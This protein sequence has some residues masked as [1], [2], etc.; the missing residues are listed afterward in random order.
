M[1]RL[2][3]TV[4]ALPVLSLCFLS[5]T[6]AFGAVQTELVAGGFRFPVYATAPPGDD[7]LFIVEQRGMIWIHEGGTT[8]ADPFLDIDSLVSAVSQFSERGLLGLAFDP[9]FDTNRLFYVSYTNNSGNSVIARYEVLAGN[10]DKADHASADIVLTQTQPFSNHNGGMIEFGPDGYLYI[11]FGD[12]GG[13]FYKRFGDAAE[14]GPFDA[15]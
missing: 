12:G 5:S 6:P 15:R 11:G 8:L 1:T 13:A 3:R 14:G 9:D 7:R 4:L 10:P 2:A